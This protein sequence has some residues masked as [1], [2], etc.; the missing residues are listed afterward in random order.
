M[1]G[2]EELG[3]KIKKTTRKAMEKLPFE[4]KGII[5]VTKLRSEVRGKKERNGQVTH[6]ARGK[7]VPTS[8]EKEDWPCRAQK[9]RK[10]NHPI[11]K[12][13]RDKE[14]RYSEIKREVRSNEKNL[15]DAHRG[16]ILRANDLHK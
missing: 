4:I 3:N 11:E 8:P 14:E 7:N 2:F 5:Q 10:Q 12:R 13:H 1:D 15:H 6:G 9:A 16:T